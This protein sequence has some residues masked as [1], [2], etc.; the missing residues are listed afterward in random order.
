MGSHVTAIG[1]QLLVIMRD[2][3][4]LPATRHKWTRAALTP[5]S[6]LVLDL[7]TP[8]GWKAKLT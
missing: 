4:V 6:N 7:P 5:A 2:H 8:E 1:R 3:T